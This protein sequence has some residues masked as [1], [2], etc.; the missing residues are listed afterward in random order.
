MAIPDA[1]RHPVDVVIALDVSGSMSGLIDSAKQR[2]WDVV[3]ELAQAN[4]RPDLRM[5]ILTYGNP[6]YGEAS[7]YVRIDMPFTRDLD[8]VN[9]TLFSFGTDGG[10]E[11]VSRVVHR[12]VTGLAWSENPD[13]LKI[14][15]V[16]GNEEANQ[17]PQISV[18]IASQLATNK[19][20]V[21][22]TIYCGN[23]DDNIV[24]GWREFSAMTNGLFASI[25][26]N[27]S[28]VANI[29]TPMDDELVR[30]NEELNTT[31]V[32]FGKDGDDYKANQVAQDVNAAEMS[33]PSVASR[34]VAKAGRL[35]RNADWDLLDALESGADLAKMDP[36]DLPEP[37]K[38]LNEEERK[39]Y[40]GQLAA[41]RETVSREIEDLGKKRQMFIAEE[42]A[43]LSDIGE[44]GLDE[45]ILNGV[46]TLA[47]KK[48][49]EFS[50]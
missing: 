32:A 15:F 37:M 24:A 42:R 20:I 26:Q 44:T 31:Y 39:E 16:A 8:A 41:K 2:L 9:R 50:Q 10:D 1:Q 13:A 48:G 17:D 4:P 14:L 33:M 19:G 40:V 43:R 34:T 6:S 27:A 38:S 47:E 5:A 30:L 12:S 29:A 11:Y 28:A 49:F 18:E 23:E 21:V 35:Y 7:G 3:N 46:R 36:A 45:A 25:N 22:N